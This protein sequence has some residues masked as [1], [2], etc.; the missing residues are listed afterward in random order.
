MLGNMSTGVRRIEKTPTMSTGEDGRHD[1]GGMAGVKASLTIH[2]WNSG[3]LESFR[4]K[5]VSALT[6][7]DPANSGTAIHYRTYDSKPI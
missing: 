6:G 3:L 5:S 1:E 7:Q 2:I 4:R